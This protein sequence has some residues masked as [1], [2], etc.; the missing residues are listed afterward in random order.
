MPMKVIDLTPVLELRKSFT[1]SVKSRSETDVDRCFQCGK[2]SAG[3]PVSFAMDLLPHQVMRLIQAGQK[4]SVLQS[5]TIWVCAQCAVCSTRCPREVGITEVME[6][7]RVMAKEEG[8]RPAQPVVE[9]VDE[10]FLSSVRS[11]GRIHEMGIVVALKMKTLRLF[12][13]MLLGVAMLSRGKLAFLPHR[14]KGRAEIKRI[15]QRV[16]E[17]VGT[18]GEVNQQ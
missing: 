12:D 16:K 6:S 5:S 11:H 13:D 7:M 2:C 4:E 15:F 1:N 8:V 14:I 9:A 10:A 18:P 17:Q 3:C